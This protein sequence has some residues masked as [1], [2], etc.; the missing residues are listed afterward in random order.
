MLSEGGLAGFQMLVSLLDFWLRR[1]HCCSES[2]SFVVLFLLVANLV[3]FSL[4]AVT[5]PSHYTCQLIA[6]V[7]LK[8]RARQKEL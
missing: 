8:N 1:C 3:L 7:S 4:Y 2:L 6:Q 5:F